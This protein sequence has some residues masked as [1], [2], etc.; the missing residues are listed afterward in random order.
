MVTLPSLP[1]YARGKWDAAS[2]IIQIHKMEMVRTKRNI[3]A[4][5]GTDQRNETQEFVNKLLS[6]PSMCVCAILR[7]PFLIINEAAPFLLPYGGRRRVLQ[8]HSHSKYGLETQLKSL[9]YL[10]VSPLCNFVHGH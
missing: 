2:L 6:M 4:Q 3:F 9:F 10:F 5:N 8:H 1:L 7:V